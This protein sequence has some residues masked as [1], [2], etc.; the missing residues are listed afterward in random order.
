MKR[1]QFLLT[2]LAAMPACAFA[3]MPADADRTRR[4]FIVRSGNNRS[5]EPMM[6]FMGLY[7]NDVV[8]SKKDT[9]DNLSVFLFAGYKGATTPLHV[10]F[11]QDEFFSVIEGKYRFVCG[12]LTEELNTGDTIFLPRNIPHQ[13]LQISENGK[14]VYEVNPAGTL[15]EMFKEFNELKSPPTE[16]ELKKILSMHGQKFLGPPLKL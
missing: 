9:D 5:G 13:W 7:P 2:T 10:H 12:T 4:P 14:L 8:I 3:K 16:D 6:K 1:K 11:N 15:E